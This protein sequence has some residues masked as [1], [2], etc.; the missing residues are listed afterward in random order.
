MSHVKLDLKSFK[1]VKSDKDSTTLRHDKGHELRLAHKSLSKEARAQLEELA[2]AAKPKDESK[3]QDKKQQFGKPEEF[4]DGGEVDE[5]G[6]PKSVKAREDAPQIINKYKAMKKGFEEGSTPKP[7]PTPEPKQNYDEGGRVFNY[8][9]EQPI[10]ENPDLQPVKDD[11]IAQEAASASQA[12]S[13]TEQ[14]QKLYN[15]EIQ[16]KSD[17]ERMLDAISGGGMGTPSPITNEMLFTN[18]K[19]PKNID[20]EVGQAALS[21]FQQNKDQETAKQAQVAGNAAQQQQ[22]A[23]AFGTQSPAAPT[24]DIAPKPPSGQPEAIPSPSMDMASMYQQGYENQ[25]K[26]IQ[27]TATAQEQLANNQHQILVD[28]ESN[29]QAVLDQY[30]QHFNAL[31]QDRQALQEDVKNGYVSP[32]KFWAGDPKTGEGGHSKILTGIGMILAGFNPT[33]SPN[34]AIKFLEYQM[35]KNMEAQ[36]SNLS[37]KENLLAANLK[38]FG[39]IREATLATQV[40]QSDMVTHQLQMA[41]T[42]AQNPMAKAAALEAAG[43]LQEAYAPKANQIAMM[44]TMK[45]L[46]NDN[47][48]D[49]E[50][51]ID[52]AISMMRIT[53]PEMAKEWESRR[54]PGYGLA[55]IPVPQEVRNEIVGK[56]NFDHMAQNYVNWVK[57]NSG[58]LNPAKINEGATLAAELQGAYRQAVKG[59]VF[60]EGEQAFIEKLIPSDPAQFASS[61]RTLPKVEALIKSNH[62]QLNTLVEGAGLRPKAR[63]TEQSQI[64]EGATGVHK[65]VPVI[66]KNGRW[67]PK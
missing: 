19:A 22:L 7:S 36:K 2:K 50:G 43:K 4:A 65:G 44:Q 49:S 56:T 27:D 67:V 46:G 12:L 61:I 16:D 66:R 40:M 45:S 48:S 17:R 63:P 37:A 25:L 9:T 55:K 1:H 18:G 29:K 8:H 34:A 54:V 52:Q 47:G 62:S 21:K 31:D 58:S 13:P 30:K 26:G 14:K 51:K 28:Q 10:E 11:S 3:E 39:N 35:D 38:H 60:K 32:D 59:G 57:K 53:N 23:G 24:S 5:F 6:Y 20:P 64:L 33:N 41:A 15:Q 42:Q